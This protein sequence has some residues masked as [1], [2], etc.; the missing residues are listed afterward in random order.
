MVDVSER[1][2]L[3]V[4]RFFVMKKEA[5]LAQGHFLFKT[6]L[7]SRCVPGAVWCGCFSRRFVMGRN[8]K[9]VLED[10]LQQAVWRTFLRGP[11]APS[12]QWAGT[13]NTVSAASKPNQPKPEPQKKTPP[14]VPRGKVPADR[15]EPVSP[16]EAVAAAR[17]RVA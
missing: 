13:R 2:S 3:V 5:I 17:Q 7:V 15:Q 1:F 14:K 11:R 10:D 12:V 4:K 6:P 16:D 8:R 9:F